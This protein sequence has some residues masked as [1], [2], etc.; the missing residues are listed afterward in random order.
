MTNDVAE[1]AAPETDEG[2]AA[3]RRW[4]AREAAGLGVALAFGV[5]IGLADSS[6]GWDSTG[7]TAM[8]L[9]LAS[10][11]A[12]FLARRRPWLVALL[13]GLPA[14]LLEIPGSGNTGSLLAL[15]FAAI[16]SAIGW[17]GS[18]PE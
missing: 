18:R 7:I 14:P 6:P 17:A 8:A 2:S 4:S 12:A 13:V 3:D 16:G 1:R 5:G 9:L 10:G 15:G 11:A